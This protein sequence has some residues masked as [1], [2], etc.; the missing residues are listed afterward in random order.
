MERW[1]Q[2]SWHKTHAR[3]RH[4]RVAL[5]ARKDHHTIDLLNLDQWTFYV[6]PTAKLDE[7]EGNQESMSLTALKKLASAITFDGLGCAVRKPMRDVAAR[8]RGH[9]SAFDLRPENSDLEMP[10]EPNYEIGLADTAASDIF[11]DPDCVHLVEFDLLAIVC[12][13]QPRG[14]PC[15]PFIAIDEAMFAGEAT[16][17]RCSQIGRIGVAVG[18]EVQRTREG[19]FNDLEVTDAVRAAVLGELSVMDG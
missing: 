11:H 8:I 3:R 15:S 14:D 1:D 18:R 12:Q 19:G 4:L 5:L 7:R 6:L 17:I 10:A 13:K 9:A 2:H 16:S